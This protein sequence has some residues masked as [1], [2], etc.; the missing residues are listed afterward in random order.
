MDVISSA[1]RITKAEIDRRWARSRYN[2]RGEQEIPERTFYRYKD[3]IQELFDIEIRCDKSAGSVYYIAGDETGERGGAKRWLLSQF[4]LSNTV[5]ESHELK[6][7]ILYENIPGGTEYLTKIVEAMRDNR[8]LRMTHSRFMSEDTHEYVIAPYCLKVF[9]Q[10][11]YIFGKTTEHH[12]PRI[13]ALDRVTSILTLP[14]TF[15]LPKDFD[16]ETYFTSSYGVFVGNQFKPELISVRVIPEV[17]AYLRSLPLH[18]SQQEIEPC[19]FSWYVAPTFD[20]I[21]E[22]RTHGSDLEVLSPARLRDLFLKEAEKTALLY[23]KM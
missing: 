3:A 7:R 9:K 10:R 4:A 23:K 13:Y 19:V 18:S 16:A 20:F 2:E 15:R 21:M 12:E 8:M 1:G 14:D 5:H 22:L 11:W 17:A 6:G